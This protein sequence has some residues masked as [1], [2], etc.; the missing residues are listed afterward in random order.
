MFNLD[1]YEWYLYLQIFDWL[2]GQLI[3]FDVIKYWVLDVDLV[4]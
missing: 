2:N 3:L 1:C 4:S